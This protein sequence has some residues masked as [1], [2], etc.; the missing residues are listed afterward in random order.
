MAVVRLSKRAWEQL[1]SKEFR[2][3][4]LRLVLINVVLNGRC[5]GQM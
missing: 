2:G 5:K 1:R 4:L 3:Y